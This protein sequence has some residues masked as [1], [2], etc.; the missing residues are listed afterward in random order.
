MSQEPSAWPQAGGAQ[1]RWEAA[2]SQHPDVHIATTSIT[3]GGSLSA[4]S[5][6]SKEK[7]GVKWQHWK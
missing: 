3:R 4:A 5:G 1:V 2:S 6:F 7:G